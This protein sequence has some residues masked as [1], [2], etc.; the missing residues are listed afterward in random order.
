MGRYLI[1][2]VGFYSCCK[3]TKNYQQQR[4]FSQKTLKF[5]ES[6]FLEYSYMGAV[7]TGTVSRQENDLIFQNTF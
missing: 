1:H 3:D 5:L 6:I 7:G 4:S 2:F